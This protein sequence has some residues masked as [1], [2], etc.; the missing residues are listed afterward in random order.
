MKNFK[1]IIFSVSIFT[2]CLVFAGCNASFNVSTKTIGGVSSNGENDGDEG[3]EF[4]AGYEVSLGNEGNFEKIKNK[5]LDSMEESDKAHYDCEDA[6]DF[7]V[8]TI[9]QEGNT[10]VFVSA[11]NGD[12]DAKNVWMENKKIYDN[13]NTQLY[14]IAKSAGLKKSFRLCVLNDENLNNALLIYQDGECIYDPIS[15]IDLMEVE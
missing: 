4:K 11:N 12:E 8:F 6:E 7:I 9:W 10:D 1:S 3:F 2:L 15:D 14:K 5:L 13:A